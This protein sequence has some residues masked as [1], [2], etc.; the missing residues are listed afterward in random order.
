MGTAVGWD[1]GANQ[2]G[3]APGAR[4]IGCRNMD[5]GLGTPATYLEC[6]EFFLAPYP[7]GGVP[8]DGDPDLAPDVTNNSWSCPASEG[9]AAGTLQAA[10][11]AMR[12]A[13][14]LTVVSANN[15]G[16]A[17]STVREPPAIYASALAVGALISG[18]DAA[19]SFSS[20]GPVTADGSGRTKPDLM[21]PGTT[22]RSSVPGGGYSSSW[23]GTSMASPHV[24]GAAAVLWSAAPW[25]RGDITATTSLLL[26]SAVPIS[27][28]DCSS[29]GV[30]N[31]TYG[32]GR[33]DVLAAVNAAKTWRLYLPVSIRGR[34]ARYLTVSVRHAG[35]RG[36]AHYPAG[37]RVMADA[38]TDDASKEGS[39]NAI[40]KYHQATLG[41]LEKIL[42]TET[43]RIKQAAGIV[44]DQ[45]AAGNLVHITGSGGHSMMGAEEMFY[46]SGG[47]VPISPI[48][49]TAFS[50][51][52]GALRSTAM[53]RTPGLMTGV[54]KTYNLKAGE[55][56]IIVNAYGINCGTID[57]AVECRR[58]GLT[59]IG[60]TSREI[61]SALPQG[62]P[63]RHPSGKN[64]PDLVDLC[65]NS[66]VPMGD[67]IVELEGYSQKVSS[68]STMANAFI[69]ECLMA[70]AIDQ[71][72]QR[73]IDPPVWK[74]ANSPGGDEYN[75]KY[76]AK[77]S[78][79][80][81]HL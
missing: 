32:Y 46:R 49:E 62:H 20:R 44:A 47:L 54:L 66:Y 11:E 28:T 52:F 77:Y 72:L 81:K 73:G 33:L 55:A 7:V 63:S 68:I 51:Y 65:I 42:A 75:R 57:T 10:T 64:L 74:S 39:M 58:M 60:I 22:I 48:Y 69:I 30:P 16:P 56:M 2:I 59:T 40:G 25:L 15:Y 23:S 36:R 38:R 27:S 35:G 37:I 19:A 78:G 9:C 6:F 1:G 17:C 61:S 8:A 76:I 71:L 53:E 43:E 14:I 31:N 67:A 80:I 5:N 79:V 45:I 70:E 29:S 50:L 4:W 12:A 21:A 26:D 18:S 3:V 13:G 24:A 34:G 41:T